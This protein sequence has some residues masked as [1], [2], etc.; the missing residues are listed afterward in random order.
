MW[1][2]FTNLES[3]NCRAMERAS[4]EETKIRELEEELRVVGS[5][6]QQ[7]EVNF[8][9]KIST[10]K[11]KKK[12]GKYLKIVKGERGESLATGGDVPAT[13]LWTAS[14]VSLNILWGIILLNLIPPDWSRPKL[15]QRILRWTFNDWTSGKDQKCLSLDSSRHKST[16]QVTIGK[17]TTTISHWKLDTES[18]Y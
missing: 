5:N 12:L 14:K 2:R 3:E 6:L 18:N 7:L 11:K 16:R 1:S 9:K 15:R 13:N 8:H 4:A 17:L 10:L